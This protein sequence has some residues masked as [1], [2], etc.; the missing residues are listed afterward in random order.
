MGKSPKKST[1]N[2]AGAAAYTNQ[3]PNGKAPKKNPK[4]SK[5]FADHTPARQARLLELEEQR[6]AKAIRNK[7]QRELQKEWQKREDARLA[8]EEQARLDEER[9][10]AE[11]K[12]R[13][14]QR[15]R[16][17]RHD[18]ATQQKAAPVLTKIAKAPVRQSSNE[19]NVPFVYLDPA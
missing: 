1:G 14:K 12:K 6:K 19:G 5:T 3:R 8:R 15:Q 11:A 17:A 18:R 9:E 10:I 2:S 13:L 7:E 16:D 4:R